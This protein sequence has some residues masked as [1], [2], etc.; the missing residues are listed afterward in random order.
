[1]IIRDRIKELRRVPARDLIPNPKNW[2]V[3]P[4]SQRA[5]LQG[6]LDE[7][8]Y[9]DAVL[10]REVSDGKLIL[11]DGHLRAETTPDQDIPVLIVDL[12]EEEADLLLA[13]HDPMAAMAYPNLDLYLPLVEHLEPDSQAV[14]ALLEAVANN[15]ARPL[16]D[17]SE[18]KSEGLT[19][20]DDVPE[21]E[22]TTFTVKVG[23]VWALGDH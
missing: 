7:I 10:A 17:L 13:V 5:A 14:S 23:E 12:T 15:E 2:R 9:A 3:H 19:D 11:I 22:E 21:I 4:D 8:G 20:P 18:P 1:M 16:Y 6:V